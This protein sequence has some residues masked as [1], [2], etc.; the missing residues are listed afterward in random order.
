LCTLQDPERFHREIRACRE[1]ASGRP[2]SA[3]LLLPIVRRGHVEACVAERLL[4]SLGG[5][6]SP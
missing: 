1:Q 3:N 4:C 2:F 5:K 6:W